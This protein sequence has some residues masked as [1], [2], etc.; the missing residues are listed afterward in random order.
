MLAEA[1][2]KGPIVL[3]FYPAAF[4]TEGYRGHAHDRRHRSNRRC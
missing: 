1:L 4:T 2:R 3:R